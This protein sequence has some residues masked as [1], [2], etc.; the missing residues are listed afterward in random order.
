MAIFPAN[1]GYPV[2]PFILSLPI[3]LI[4]ITGNGVVEKS[5]FHP[6]HWIFLREFQ[7]LWPTLLYSDTQSL[8]GFSVIRKCM[9]TKRDS[10]CFVP[11]HH[12]IGFKLVAS[13]QLLIYCIHWKPQ[14]LHT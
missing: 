1:L 11:L 4:V 14:A 6:F 13:N 10:R 3:N 2:A 5:N 8:I 12:S 7:T 9:T